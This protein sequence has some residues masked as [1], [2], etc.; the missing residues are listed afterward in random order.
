MGRA[1][2]GGFLNAKTEEQ[3]MREGLADAC[4]FAKFNGDRHE[5]SDNYHGSFHFYDRVF[6][7]E[8]DAKDFFESL[9]DYCDGVCVVK[10]AEKSAQT[11]Y[12]KKVA[13]INKKKREFFD[14]VIEKFKERT[15]KTVGC[16]KCGTRIDSEAAVNRNL[17]CPNCYNWMVPDSVKQRYEQF[18]EQLDLAKK[19]YQKDTAETGKPRYWARYSVHN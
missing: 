17:R 12:N 4:A 7:N 11:K 19:Q 2:G 14:K 3:A 6:D 8:D 10:K 5:G 9:G 15:S 13:T 16:K 1:I 18:N